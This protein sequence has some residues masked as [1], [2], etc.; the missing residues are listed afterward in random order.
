MSRFEKL[1]QAKLKQLAQCKPLVA[2]SLCRVNPADGGAT[3]AAS[4]R[5]GNFTRRTC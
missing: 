2:A 5:G 3:P 1:R 4:V